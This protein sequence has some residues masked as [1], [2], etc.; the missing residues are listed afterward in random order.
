MHLNSNNIN[1]SYATMIG[2]GMDEIEVLE[3]EE[4]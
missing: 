4:I 1:L 2:K 3:K